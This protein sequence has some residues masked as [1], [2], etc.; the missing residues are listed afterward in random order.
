MKSILLLLTLVV[1]VIADTTILGNVIPT[2]NDWKKTD[3]ETNYL[4]LETLL[5]NYSTVVNSSAQIDSNITFNGVQQ[6]T[7]NIGSGD[8]TNSTISEYGNGRNNYT[9]IQII[10]TVEISADTVGVGFLIYK[11]PV[12]ECVINSACMKVKIVHRDSNIVADTPDGGL[13]TTIASG[14]ISVLSSNA[15]FENIL[16]G[17]TFNNCNGTV[18]KKTVSNQVLTVDS[19]SSHNIYFN[20]AD[21]WAG[22]DSGAVISGTVFLNWSKLD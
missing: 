16:T 1:F 14:T 2:K 8:S 11:L 10:D 9:I 22:T 21:I 5:K 18:E 19:A 7:A 12:G 15:A 17:Q 6:N 20:F 13:G 3:K 4:R